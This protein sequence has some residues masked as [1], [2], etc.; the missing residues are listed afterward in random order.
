M[1]RRLNI[2]RKESWPEDLHYKILEI[3][4]KPFAWGTHDCFCVSSELIES[5]TGVDPAKDYRGKYSTAQG[6]LKLIISQGLTDFLSLADKI[7]SDNGFKEVN[8]KFAQRGD[9]CYF[10]IDGGAFGIVN[11]CGLYCIVIGESGLKKLSVMEAKKAW[12]I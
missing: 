4:D 7:C 1:G 6:M 5:M 3:K 10:D 8:L 12:H 9:V 2:M 11:H